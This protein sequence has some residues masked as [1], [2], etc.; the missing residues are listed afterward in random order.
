MSLISVSFLYVQETLVFF[1]HVCRIYALVNTTVQYVIERFDYTVSNEFQQVPHF[2][3]HQYRCFIIWK[4][5]TLPDLFLGIQ[6]YSVSLYISTHS[7][8]LANIFTVSTNQQLNSFAISV[9]SINLLPS[10]SLMQVQSSEDFYIVSRS[11]SPYKRVPRRYSDCSLVKNLN[12]Y[13]KY[14]NNLPQIFPTYVSETV[15]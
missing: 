4:V 5:L 2:L 15:V 12:L 3:Y 14:E 7:I 9:I 11:L 10:A 8:L 6:M 1:F 13:P